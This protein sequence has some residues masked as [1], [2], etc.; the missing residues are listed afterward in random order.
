MIHY[1]RLSD[2]E[3][4]NI[5]RMLSQ[6]YSF[7]NIAKVLK[8]NVSTIGREIN[9]SNCNKY[10]YRAIKAKNRVRRN[11]ARRKTGKHKLNDNLDL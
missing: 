5:S 7:R 8:R 1:K 6:E 4:E 3:R 11:S 9:A 2:L 10:N